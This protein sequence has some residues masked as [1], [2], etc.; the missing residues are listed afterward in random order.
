MHKF[1]NPARFLIIAKWL[2][3]LLLLSG[4]LL[5]AMSL[6]WGFWQVPADRLMGD[7]VRILFIH[8]PTAWLGMGGWTAIAIASLV[9]LVWRHPLAAIAARATAVPGAVFTFI[10]LATGSI[11]GRP[12]WGTW[13]VWDGR[14][15]SMLVLLFLYFGY[16]ALSASL[17]R[18]GQS[19]RIAAIFGLVGAI[20]VPIIN[21]SVVWWNSLHQPPSITL[22]QSS[23]DSVF[24]VPLMIAVAGFSLLFG[25]VVLARMR[26]ILADIQTEARLRRRVQQ[27]EMRSDE[28]SA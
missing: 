7:T 4:L 18:E 11:W 6:S 27:A 17:A 10:C 23:I 16:I 20:N 25:G 28:A 24:L 3:P 12:T 5:C 1:A 26:A 19:S 14:L 21:R 13:W 15:T 22:G 8:V 2:T 9:E